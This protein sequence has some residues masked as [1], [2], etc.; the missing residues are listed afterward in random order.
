MNDHPAIEYDVP[1]APLREPDTVMRLSRL[2]SF[3]PTRLSFMRSLVRQLSAEQVEVRR[4]I[5]DIDDAGY[6]RAVYS[7]ELGGHVYSLVAFSTRLSP[8]QRTDRVIAEAWDT[9]YALFDGVPTVG[10]LDRLEANA[11]KQE[12]GRFAA[13]ELV[14]SRANKSVRFFDHVIDR[15]SQGL[16]PDKSLVGS[17]G[18]LM[19]TTAVYGNGKFGIADRAHIADRPQLSGSFQPELL[20]VWLIRGFSLDLV[21]HIARSKAPEESVPLDRD[22]KRHLASVILP[23]WAW[24]LFW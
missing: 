9:S 21:E 22:L 11:P 2:G 5:W 16:Q 13:S 17:I 24:L 23:A 19:R 3:Y 1:Q 12:A 7:L 14:I 4:P 10:D 8:D 15:L 20:T 6:G 18:Y